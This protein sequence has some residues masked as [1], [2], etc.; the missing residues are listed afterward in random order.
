[1]K[2]N[3]IQIN[4]KRV[5]SENTLHVYYFF[6]LCNYIEIENPVPKNTQYE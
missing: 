4:F 2:Q 1:M 5:I 6:H 3:V